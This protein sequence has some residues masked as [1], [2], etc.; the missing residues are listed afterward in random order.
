MKVYIVWGSTG[1]HG[2]YR[3]WIAGIF[4]NE[5]DAKEFCDKC[6]E[7]ADYMMEDIYD[8]SESAKYPRYYSSDEYE[9]GPDEAFSIDYTGTHYMIGEEIVQ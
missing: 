4:R 3:E 8:E 9:D 6:Q 1:E 5:N 2:D 7:F